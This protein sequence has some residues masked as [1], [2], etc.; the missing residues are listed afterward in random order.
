MRN[1]GVLM[2]CGLDLCIY[3]KDKGCILSDISIDDSGLCA[4]S[5]LVSIERGQL[6]LYKQLLLDKYMAVHKNASEGTII[7]T[8]N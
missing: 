3:N 5:I 7:E 2:R 6:E 1:R 8:I 4:D